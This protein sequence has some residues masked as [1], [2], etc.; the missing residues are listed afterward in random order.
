MKDN[1]FDLIDISAG[2]VATGEK[3]IPEVGTE[4]FNYILDVASGTKIPI[5]TSM[6][7]ITTY[8]SLI[9]P[10]LPDKK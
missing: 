4:I 1:W 2:G 5:P 6:A 7:S 9:R 3:T 8:V 10:R